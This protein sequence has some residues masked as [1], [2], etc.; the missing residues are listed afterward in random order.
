MENCIYNFAF[1]KAIKKLRYENIKKGINET[2]FYPIF[3]LMV[4]MNNY[5]KI[6]K[7]DL[8]FNILQDTSQKTFS[9]SSLT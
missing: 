9:L 4:V 6:D 2:P 8:S 5:R 3:R 7:W 1:I